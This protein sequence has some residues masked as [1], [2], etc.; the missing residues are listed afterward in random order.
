MTYARYGWHW[1]TLPLYLIVAGMIA[2]RAGY[3][4][5]QPKAVMALFC[6]AAAAFVAVDLPH[7]WQVEFYP[8]CYGET[9][10][11]VIKASVRDACDPAQAG[12]GTSVSPAAAIAVN[13]VLLAVGIGLWRTH[14]FP[15][16]ALA[17]LAM[18]AAA[19]VPPSLV[20]PM[21]G[22]AGEPVFSAG[23]IAAGIRFGGLPVPHR[24]AP[25]SA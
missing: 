6:I 10:R 25:V 5:A 14:R 22:N 15:W 7:L 8:A 20:G 21:L 18:F 12:L 19:A 17:C 24:A 9:L 2:R 16:L 3:R 13:L 1:A 23:L 11:L 4:W